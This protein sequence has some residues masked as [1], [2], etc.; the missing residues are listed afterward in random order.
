L[1]R[2]KQHGCFGVEQDPGVVA[3]AVVNMIF[4]GD[5]KN[6]IIEG[7]CFAKYLSPAVRDGV[8]T[9][10]YTNAP[11]PEPPVTKV[12]MNPPFALRRSDEKEY[13]FVDQAL[14]QVQHGGLLFT[15]LPYS[16]M[17]RPKAYQNWRQKLLL[18][19]NTLLAVVTFPPDLFYPVGVTT[20]GVLIKK[21]TPHPPEQ[22]VLW[23]RAIQDGF[24]IS[25]K[26]RLPSLR[27]RNDLETAKDHLR[28]F[29]YNPNYPAPNVD[30]FMKAAP[31]N[32]DDSL[33]ELVPEA[34]LDQAEPTHEAVVEGLTDRVRR[35][36]AYLVKIDQAVFTPQ[37]MTHQQ[38]LVPPP[39]GWKRLKV[40]DLFDLDR[41]DFHSLAD[42]D[43]G[44]FPTIS[45]IGTDNGLEG[46]YD[47]PEGARLWPP[48]TIT[49]SSV[50]ADAFLQPVSFI[51]TD[52]VVLCTLKEEYA[53]IDLECLMFVELVLNDIRWRY[54]YGRQPYKT[55]LAEAE[56]VLPTDR[57]GEIDWQYMRDMVMNTKHWPL[58]RAAFG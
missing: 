54:S 16:A 29:I 46:F 21:G 9:A 2:F 47:K 11:S 22:K 8:P 42:L 5:G 13:R 28:A 39:A 1:D 49:V 38:G 35:K 27:V 18:A 31:M 26:K 19:N 43:P 53:D 55:K 25:K 14:K 3:L 45:R 7:N 12:M 41:G 48:R 24:A 34:Y 23:V 30:Q 52:N 57:N 4:R 44:T 20:V 10:Q 56:F 32:T 40:T 37:L 33:L 58:V 15:V 6:N 50:S 17:V 36:L 51:A